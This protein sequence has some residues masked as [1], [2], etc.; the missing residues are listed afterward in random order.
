V[1]STL[2]GGYA[3]AVSRPTSGATPEMLARL[4]EAMRGLVVDG[5]RIHDAQ[6][7][8]EVD[9]DG[10]P[11]VHLNLLLDDPGP[12]EPTW[13]VDT[14]SAIGRLARQ[15]AWQRIGIPDWI[16]V[17]RVARCEAERGGFPSGARGA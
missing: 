11:M 5:I 12:G 8:T 16:F 9:Y 13:P 7:W 2:G 17:S 15:E 10:E 6:A 14:L 4:V 1:S 3:G